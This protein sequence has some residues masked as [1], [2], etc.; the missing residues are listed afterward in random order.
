MNELNEL[1]LSIIV[2][3]CRYVDDFPDLGNLLVDQAVQELLEH[4]MLLLYE[5][6]SGMPKFHANRES[7][8]VYMKA[9][10]E[11]PLPKK[12]WVIES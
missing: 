7:C 10:L 4:G 6:G 3:Y 9:L 8:G 12:V 2:W 1:K 5:T 11:V